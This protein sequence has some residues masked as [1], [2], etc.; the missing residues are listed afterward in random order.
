MTPAPLPAIMVAPNGARLSKRDHPAIPMTIG[1]I[2]ACARDCHTAGAGGMHVHVRDAAGRHVLD[3]GL[4]REVL[5]ELAQA[6]PGMAVQVTTEAA[7]RYEAPAQRQ[8]VRHLRPANVSISV[9]EML[10]DGARSAAL[11]LYHWCLEAGIAV[12]HILYDLADLRL[13]S[14]LDL[15]DPKPQL[16]FV[17][18]RYGARGGQPGDLQPFLAEL[19][20]IGLDADWAA[21]A[22]GSQ[23]IA[24]LLEA[25]RNGGKMR[26]GFENNC[27][28]PEGHPATGNAARVAELVA[29]LS[30]AG[31]QR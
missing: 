7:G 19:K 20:K 6:V 17:L 14:E 2:V 16:L 31:L 26:I 11:D 25:A 13:F 27:L 4:Y 5:A 24:C 15:P 28:D 9:R 10:S 18:G 29:A 23:E 12:Q 22:F 21:C 8:L 1:E 3:A 30:A